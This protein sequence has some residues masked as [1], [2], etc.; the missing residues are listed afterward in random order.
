M[1]NHDE[2]AS[3]RN[4]ETRVRTVAVRRL[5]LRKKSERKLRQWAMPSLQDMI[6]ENEEG[7]PD[8]YPMKASEV[9]KI[10]SLYYKKRIPCIKL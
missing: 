8:D 6:P 7:S 1:T 4:A 3:E 2:A 10:I 5:S 9:F